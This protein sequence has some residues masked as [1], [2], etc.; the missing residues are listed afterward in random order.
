MKK[1][2]SNKGKYDDIIN[3]P[4]HRSKTRPHMSLL[5]RAAQFSPFAA[6]TGHEEAIEETARLT[7]Q[8]AVLTK[9]AK[10][11]LNEKLLLI[12]KNLD[13]QPKIS[14]TYFLPDQQKS[15]GAYI[16]ETGTVKK[17]DQFEH[18]LIMHNNVIIPIDD[19]SSIAGELFQEYD[20]HH[21]LTK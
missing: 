12:E 19:I 16:T 10:A 7:E 2:P 15:G 5:D 11:K 9:E 1:H 6:L 3:L 4:N 8:K 18:S 17:I 14:I 13:K 20:I 21:P